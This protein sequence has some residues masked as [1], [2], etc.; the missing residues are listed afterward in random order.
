M[1]LIVAEYAG[2]CFG[3]GRAL[4]AAYENIEKGEPLYSLGPIIHN[5]QVVSE[6]EEKGVTVIN[7]ADDAVENSTVI[8]R[9]HGVA[10]EVYEKLKA[11][12]VNIIDM[13]CPYVKRIH[14][15]V[16]KYRKMGY[17][18]IIIGEKDHPEVIGING[19]ADNKCIVVNSPED[20]ESIQPSQKPYCIVAQTTTVKEKWDELIRKILKRLPN[21]EIFCT[22][23]SATSNRQREAV[24]IA[25][26]ADT[27]LVIGGRNSSNTRKLVSI[28]REY[29][30]KTY[31]VEHIDD[32]PD[33]PTEDIVGITA[34][35]STPEWL[36]KEVI[37]KMNE[38]ISQ[39]ETSFAE[40]MDRMFV[41]IKNG[42]I[43]KG[44]VVLVNSNEIC[45][46]IGYKSDGIIPL[47]ELDLK[48]NED[49]FS[50]YHVG[51]EI[52]AEVLK[53]NDGEGN[54]LLS[55]RKVA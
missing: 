54:V 7:S 24:R 27:M 47:N 34:G 19:W 28:C 5:P 12:N 3:V 48:P 9:S 11:K 8:I 25:K 15:T 33:I 4:K 36:I 17:D 45:V 40:A 29:C 13:T 43:V 26:L 53:V 35:A 37:S 46:N 16:Q 21:S 10:P 6:L 2:F 38:K 22:I 30:E 44:T 52:E 14:E 18:I 55:E 42:Q 32:I 41:S 49:I 1:K 51:D 20:V 31:A 50:K 39:D 23:C